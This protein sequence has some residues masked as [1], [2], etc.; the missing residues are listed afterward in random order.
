MIGNPKEV[1]Q[2]HSARLACA[3]SPNIIR[4]TDALYAEGLLIPRS[5]KEKMLVLAIEDYA[6]ASYLVNVIEGQLE[7]SLNPEQYL[8]S[9]CRV[10][11]NQQHQTL[12]DIAT[13]MLHQLGKLI[14]MVYSKNFVDVKIIQKNSL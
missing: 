4:V 12:I 3:I 1:L 5:A 6:K 10:L 9:V 13:T 7:S 8:I 14:V 11:I 2:T